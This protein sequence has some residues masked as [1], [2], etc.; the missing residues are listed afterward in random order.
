[1][2]PRVSDGDVVELIRRDAPRIVEVRILTTSAAELQ[3]R[4]QSLQED[5]L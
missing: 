3:E 1:M 5:I 2:V 4:D